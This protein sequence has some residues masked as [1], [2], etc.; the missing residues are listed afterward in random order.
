MTNRHNIKALAAYIK[1]ETGGSVALTTWSPG[2]G[3]TRYR[4]GRSYDGLHHDYDGD[5]ALCTALG[6]AAAVA[7]LKGFIAGMEG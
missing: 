1:L 6:A 3:L 5:R 2:D 7:M 4:L